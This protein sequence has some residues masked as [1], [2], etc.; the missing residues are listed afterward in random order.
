[1]PRPWHL[2]QF[3]GSCDAGKM[4]FGDLGNTVGCGPASHSKLCKQ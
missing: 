1:M 4:E 2:R 3:S